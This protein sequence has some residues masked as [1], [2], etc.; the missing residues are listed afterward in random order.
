MNSTAHST[1]LAGNPFYTVSPSRRTTV[2]LQYTLNTMEC[3]HQTMTFIHSDREVTTTTLYVHTVQSN[4]VHFSFLQKSPLLQK[5]PDWEQWA[6]YLYQRQ[7]PLYYGTVIVYLSIG[8][9]ACHAI[10]LTVVIV[11]SGCFMSK[12]YKCWNTSHTNGT[13]KTPGD[14]HTQHATDTHTHN[15]HT[16]THTHT[17]THTYTQHAT[18]M[19]PVQTKHNQN[20]SRVT[21]TWKNN[22]QAMCNQWFI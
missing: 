18:H 9:S 13:F 11:V 19:L 20:C 15:T 7:A 3:N 17:L 12:M 21:D 2:E 8:V 1:V 14:R 10:A 16:H 4:L 22:I 6:T 5:Y